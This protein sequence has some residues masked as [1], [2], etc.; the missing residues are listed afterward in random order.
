MNR[1]IRRQKQLF[2]ILILLIL[3]LGF[4]RMAFSSAG[5]GGRADSVIVSEFSA[6]G[7]THLLDEDGEPSD[8][9]ELH[10]P[11]DQA[12]DLFGWSLTDDP[13]EPDK[14]VFPQTILPPDGYLL[15]FASGKDRFPDEAGGGRRCSITTSTFG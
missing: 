15:L 8:W 6:T 13:A 10:N 4:G 3:G 14:W 5:E 9:I 7:S 12:V 1:R 2:W 11:S